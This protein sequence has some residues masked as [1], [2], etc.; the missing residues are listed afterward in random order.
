[1]PKLKPTCPR[2]M[3]NSWV[4]GVSRVGGKVEKLWWKGFVEKM[5]FE[6]GVEVRSNVWRQWWR[7]KWQQ[8]RVRSDKNDKSETV[9]D[10]VNTDRSL[11]ICLADI[12]FFMVLL[13][14]D[15]HI[16]SVSQETC[17]KF[18]WN[19]QHFLAVPVTMIKVVLKY[20]KSCYNKSDSTSL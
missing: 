15:S 6:P 5:S 7:R 11:K 1:M 2:K 4:H 19:L 8:T 10:F 12:A 3:K 17:C 13:Y 9:T 16:N 14:T 20:N 18:C